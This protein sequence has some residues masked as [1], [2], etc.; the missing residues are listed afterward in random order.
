G[1]EKPMKRVLRIPNIKLSGPVNIDPSGVKMSGVSLVLPHS[2]LA[3]KGSVDKRGFDLWGVGPVSLSD[4]VEIAE[5]PIAG[6]GT[7]TVHAHGPSSRVLIDFDGDLKN[8]KYL[9]LKLGDFAGRITWDD[10]PQYLIFDHIKAVKNQTN[11]TVNGKLD[12]GKIES[13]DLDVG[14][15]NGNIYDLTQIFEDFTQSLWWFPRTLAG[16]VSGTAKVSGGLLMSQLV[17]TTD[18]QGHDWEYFGERIR[19]VNAR[20][21]Y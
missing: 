10:D 6:D 3:V 1:M 20:G 21:G 12:L 15:P 19:T 13:A 7:L 2:K 4:L 18:L 17:I 9:R 8:A 5:V 16:P 11:Y 14:I